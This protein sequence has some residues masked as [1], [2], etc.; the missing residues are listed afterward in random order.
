MRRW[1]S[2]VKKKFHAKAQS[3]AFKKQAVLNPFA[4]LREIKAFHLLGLGFKN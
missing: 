4:P 3:K 1:E 2:I